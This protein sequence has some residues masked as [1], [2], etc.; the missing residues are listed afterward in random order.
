MGYLAPYP[1]AVKR[2]E[3][4]KIYFHCQIVAAGDLPPLALLQLRRELLRALTRLPDQVEAIKSRLQELIQPGLSPDPLQRS[5]VQKPAPPMVI[6]PDMSFHGSID[7]GR[8]L[9]LPVLLIGSGVMALEPLVR[10]VEELGRNGLYQGRCVFSLEALETEDNSGLRAM[11]TNTGVDQGELTPP[12][13]EL[14]WWLDRQPELADPVELRF[15]SP[16][17]LLQRGRPLFKAD[18]GAIFPF[19]LR[20]VSSML[21]AHGEEDFNQ[22][23][24]ALIEQAAAIQTSEN[25]LTWCDWR[26]LQGPRQSQPLGGLQGSLTLAG[27]GLAELAWAL[28]LGA[29]FNVGKGAAWGSGQYSL[30]AA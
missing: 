17:R 28:R 22:D 29:L 6:Y 10:L 2:L 26:T 7:S 11:L 15:V 3:Y 30:H 24:S 20:R 13:N 4:V 12:V 8:R 1:A 19:I 16:V 5:Q 25:R 23:A 9:V 14:G 27:P 18:F 21:A